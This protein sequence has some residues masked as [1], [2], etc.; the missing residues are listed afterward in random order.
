MQS[1]Q[2]GVA[3]EVEIATL[4]LTNTDALVLLRVV[5]LVALVLL[6][7]MLVAPVVFR[8]PMSQNW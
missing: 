5:M 1:T 7:E 4:V 2:V 6:R 8:T 3:I